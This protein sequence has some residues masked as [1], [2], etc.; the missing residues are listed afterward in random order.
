VNFGL[1]KKDHGVNSPVKIDS[2]RAAIRSHDILS[3]KEFYN[4]MNNVEFCQRKAKG[5]G[6]TAT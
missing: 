5:K 4:P 1:E 2:L 6:V 3:W